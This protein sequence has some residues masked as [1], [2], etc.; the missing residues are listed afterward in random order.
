MTKAFAKKCRLSW[1]GIEKLQICAII[2]I[3]T[4]GNYIKV[5]QFLKKYIV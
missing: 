4:G 3:K 5:K 1:I 2:Q